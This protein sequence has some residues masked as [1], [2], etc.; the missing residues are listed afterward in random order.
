MR[1]G[2]FMLPTMPHREGKKR[3]T[4]AVLNCTEVVAVYSPV[5]CS[6]AAEGSIAHGLE[7]PLRSVRHRPY[8]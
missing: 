7:Q 8:C 3:T 1:Y 4:M 6:L 5:C 2:P